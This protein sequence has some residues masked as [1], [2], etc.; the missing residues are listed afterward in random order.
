MSVSRAFAILFIR[1][2]AVF[3]PPL[4]RVFL[5]MIPMS[6][7]ALC[8]SVTLATVAS[9]SSLG[10][11]VIGFFNVNLISLLCLTGLCGKISLLSLVFMVVWIPAIEPLY[12]FKKYEKNQAIFLCT[13]DTHYA[14]G[15]YPIAPNGTIL[16]NETSCFL[17]LDWSGGNACK[18]NTRIC[19][20]KETET[21]IYLTY[22]APILTLCFV[23]LIP[24]LALLTFHVAKKLA[25][26]SESERNQNLEK[27][28]DQLKS[29]SQVFEMVQT[30]M[31]R[32]H[33]HDKGTWFSFLC[34]QRGV[35]KRIQ[36]EQ[37][38]ESPG[39]KLLLD[40]TSTD[41]T[42]LKM[43][44]AELIKEP[45]SPVPENTPG[46]ELNRINNS[47]DSNQ[48]VVAIEMAPLNRERNEDTSPVP[49]SNSESV[50][51]NSEEDPDE[52]KP[53][54]DETT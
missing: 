27:I 36:K 6:L 19:D 16:E 9:A 39:L 8:A 15:F 48:N 10:A 2:R 50:S 47:S 43:F 29:E 34:R 22:I 21:Q 51:I 49:E 44:W 40:E 20:V 1:K 45:D 25:E 3:I 46:S 31:K 14:P 37:P 41:L 26:K 30:E 53:F 24:S 54:L 12:S 17:D 23:I 18:D 33:K 11:L 13:N 32:G 5:T 42:L 35:L 28:L 4:R 38:T 52:I 7:F